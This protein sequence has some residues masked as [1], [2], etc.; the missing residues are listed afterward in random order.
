[1]KR[2]VPLPPPNRQNTKQKAVILENLWF[3]SMDNEETVK[4]KNVIKGSDDPLSI[5]LVP[6]ICLHDPISV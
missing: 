6:H 1:M 4:M 5:S 3:S 2:V